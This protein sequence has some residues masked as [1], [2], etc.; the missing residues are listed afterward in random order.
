VVW[1][2]LRLAAIGLGLGVAAA[3]GAVRI[4]AGLLYG[5]RPLD[6]ATFVVVF[7]MLAATALLACYLPA[8]R[9]MSVDPIIALRN[10]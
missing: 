3:A 7:G 8:R 6:P 9:A 10:E 2:G 4:L 5:V 1:R